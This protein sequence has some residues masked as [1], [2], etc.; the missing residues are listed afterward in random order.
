MNIL[1]SSCYTH[2]ELRALPISGVGRAS[3][4]INHV[5]KSPLYA[6]FLWRFTT[7]DRGLAQA[8]NVKYKAQTTY[9]PSGKLEAVETLE[10]L[11]FE[12]R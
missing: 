5:R 2:Y 11:K 8:S 7:Q 1:P 10:W 3:T 12:K 4:G 6:A 9:K